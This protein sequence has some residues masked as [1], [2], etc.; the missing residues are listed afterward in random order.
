MKIEESLKDGVV[1]LS[2]KGKM[3]DPN[4]TDLHEK[5]KKLIENGINKVIIDLG[6]V[7]WINSRGLGILSSCYASMKN[8]GGRMLI[9]RASDKINSI[10][11]ITKLNTI[12]ETYPSVEEA[13]EAIQK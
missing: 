3:T 5:V 2:I 8:S 4:I 6:R 13:V 12:L 7:K 1:I 11:M 9:A 10:L